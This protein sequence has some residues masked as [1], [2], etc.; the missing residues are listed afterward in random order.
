MESAKGVSDIFIPRAVLEESDQKNSIKVGDICTAIVVANEVGSCKWKALCVNKGPKLVQKKLNQC[1]EK[2]LLEKRTTIQVETFTGKLTGQSGGSF[3]MESARGVS[4]IYIPLEVVICYPA[5]LK[6]GDICT[7]T[8]I[9]NEVGS[10]KWKAINL[11]QQDK[12]AEKERVA[13]KPTMESLKEKALL[14]LLKE[15][16]LNESIAV[17]TFRKLQEEGITADQLRCSVDE[18]LLKELQIKSGARMAIAEWQKECRKCSLVTSPPA[19]PDPPTLAI[20]ELPMSLLLYSPPCCLRKM[21]A[22][23]L[24]AATL[25][26]REPVQFSLVC[27]D[28]LRRLGSFKPAK[29]GPGPGEPLRALLTILY[30]LRNVGGALGCRF[31]LAL[32]CSTPPPHGR[33]ALSRA[34]DIVR[35]AVGRPVLLDLSRHDA[36]IRH[37]AA[38]F[39]QLSLSRLADP[40][41]DG[42]SSSQPEAAADGTGT[43]LSRTDPGVRKK[44]GPV[45]VCGADASGEEHE[46]ETDGGAYLVR[47]RYPLYVPARDGESLSLEVVALSDG[48]AAAVEAGLR[49]LSAATRAAHLSLSAEEARVLE[50]RFPVGGGGGGGGGG[51]DGEKQFLRRF[52][53]TTGCCLILDKLL[54]T[55][56]VAGLEEDL[57][58][59]VQELRRSLSASCPSPLRDEPPCR[60][61]PAAARAAYG[62]S[63]LV[64]Q[65]SQAPRATVA[66]QSR[67]LAH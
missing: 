2:V 24:S 23:N 33:G 34:A 12:F 10:C 51:D 57:P 7:A 4:N 21:L 54:Q 31:E 16:G 32:L 18:A 28:A 19:C 9:Q 63:C 36:Y 41:G 67:P 42:A 64:I 38:R 11:H 61:R 3:F 8:V 6:I 30:G 65:G 20:P 53:A 35:R 40:R 52:H 17:D 25:S 59:G 49:R 37:A 22:G 62:I 5:T 58:G 29:D 56:V 14:T 48:A 47:Q 13:C 46:S 15:L 66:A 60:W 55:A 50:A 1:S 26:C 39:I 43:L 27:E 45:P 44:T